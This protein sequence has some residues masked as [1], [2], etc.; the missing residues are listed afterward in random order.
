MENIYLD[1]EEIGVIGRVHP[2]IKKD[3]IYVCEVKLYANR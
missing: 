1:R 3:D 2:S